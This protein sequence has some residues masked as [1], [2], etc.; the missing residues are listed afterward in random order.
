MPAKTQVPGRP[1]D[2]LAIVYGGARESA[3]NNRRPSSSGDI[4]VVAAWVPAGAAAS[5]AGIAPDSTR[6]IRLDVPALLDRMLGRTLDAPGKAT[7][8]REAYRIAGTGHLGHR[9]PDEGFCPRFNKYSGLLEWSNAS[10]FLWVNLGGQNGGSA[11]PYPNQFRQEGR[12]INWY[13]SSNAQPDSPAMQRLVETGSRQTSGS[14]IGAGGRTAKPAERSRSL[15]KS[16]DGS[17][18]NGDEQG[19]VVLWCRRYDPDRRSYEPYVCL[20][21]L[22]VRRN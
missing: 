6:A 10:A 12:F 14:T 18:K 5:S 4:P 16:G 22:R 11:S 2:S 1:S 20:G 13:A 3:R 8:V 15:T 21:R 17:D 19:G 7:V 9:H